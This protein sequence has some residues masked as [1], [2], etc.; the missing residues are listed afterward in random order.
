M[1]FRGFVKESNYRYKN[2][3][4]II[5]MIKP[6]LVI[7]AAGMGSRYGGLKQIDGVGPAGEAIIEYSIYDAIRAGFGKVVFVIRE[8]IETAFKAKFANKFDDKIEIAYAFQAVDT[9]IKGLEE[10]PERE[11]PWGTAHAVLVAKDVVNEPFCV[12]N[13]DDYY[14]ATAFQSIADFLREKCTPDHASMVGYELLK[15]LSDHGSVNRGVC[16]M[17]EE[18][19]LT[20]TNERTK[21]TKEAEGIFYQENDSKHPL[22]RDSLVSMNLWGFHPSIFETMRVQFI[23]FVKETVGQ[24]KA[25]FFIPL[26]VNQ[27]IKTGEAK[28]SV[29]PNSERWYGVTYKEDKPMVEK[30]FA[31]MTEEGKYPTPLWS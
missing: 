8:D 25:E 27:Q 5:R 30:A 17:N 20:D 18:G 24:P 14:G 3:Q 28:V 11:K 16:E 7:L 2:S 13:A 4:K 31:A 10:M 19:L 22:D 1:N 15:T 29:L 6:A 9:P 12:I 23:D 26:V 21:I